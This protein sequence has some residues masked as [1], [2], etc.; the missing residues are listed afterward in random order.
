VAH[1]KVEPCV[2]NAL[3]R[4]EFIERRIYLG[5]TD[6]LNRGTAFALRASTA[7][8][9]TATFGGCAGL[10]GLGCSLGCRPRTTDRRTGLRFRFRLGGGSTTRRIASVQFHLQER[11]ARNGEVSFGDCY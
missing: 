7:G 11:L 3:K 8:T 1:Q 10:V 4:I 6:A 5:C 2:A 9:I